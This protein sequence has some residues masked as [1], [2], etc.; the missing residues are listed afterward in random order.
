MYAEPLK[1][2]M[3]IMFFE[4]VSSKNSESWTEPIKIKSWIRLYLCYM[5]FW[6]ALNTTVWNGKSIVMISSYNF[7][8]ML[9]I[10]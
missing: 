1:I 5:V 10:C 7:S 8:N 4:H 6:F 3:N 9:M 2:S